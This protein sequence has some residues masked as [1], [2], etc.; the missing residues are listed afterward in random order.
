MIRILS[1]VLG[2]VF[3]L[4]FVRFGHYCWHVRVTWWVLPPVNIA[5]ISPVFTNE[6]LHSGKP[7]KQ[8]QSN[9]VT[10][11][12]R[13][14]SQSRNPCI[15]RWSDN[16]GWSSLSRISFDTTCTSESSSA[17]GTLLSCE[18]WTNWIQLAADEIK[19]L[20][21]RLQNAIMCICFI[22]TTYHHMY[23]KTTSTSG[24]PRAQNL[25]N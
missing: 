15:S 11:S 18:T 1:P 3:I 16:S 22:F 7:R 13:S 9:I 4:H 20:L 6:Q 12:S 14:S 5:T 8:K 2:F 25:T 21:S 23:Q 10:C 19:K 24:P 17:L